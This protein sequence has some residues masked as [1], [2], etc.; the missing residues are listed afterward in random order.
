MKP[1]TYLIGW[2]KYNIWYYGVRY[3][4]NCSPSDLWVTYFTS[5]NLVNE[6]RLKF[7][8][9]D[10]IQ[11]RK[12]FNDPHKAKLWESKVLKKMSA[13][14]DD[15]FLNANDRMAPPI[16]TKESLANTSVTAKGDKRT[17]NQLIASKAH[18]N[19][20]KGR[21]SDKKIPTIVFGITYS[22]QSEAMKNQ[23]LSYGQIKIYLNSPEKFANSEEVKQ[24]ALNLKREK[25][26]FKNKGRPNLSAG[27]RLSEYNKTRKGIPHSL[28][29]NKKV[30]EALKGK[31][32]DIVE[33][34]HCN[35]KGGI[36]TM[37]RWHFDNCKVKKDNGYYKSP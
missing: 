29:H 13:V 21:P 30:S 1:F 16:Q 14:K 33:C 7:G 20:M 6:A 15:R 34:Y 35:K 4:N 23:K 10:I 3:A 22:S 2:K 24:Y 25:I 27:K 9:P 12:T 19:K 11:V 32:A 26:S 28:D 37:K 8:E 36:N 18:S 5:S 31:K 17:Q